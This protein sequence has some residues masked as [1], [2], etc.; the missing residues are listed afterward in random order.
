MRRPAARRRCI[1]CRGPLG[2][3][4]RTR[5]SPICCGAPCGYVYLAAVMDWFSRRVLAWRV[6]ILSYYT[7]IR[8]DYLLTCFIISSTTKRAPALDI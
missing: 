6:S 7:L 3:T 2:V 8:T 1:A 4:R 5:C